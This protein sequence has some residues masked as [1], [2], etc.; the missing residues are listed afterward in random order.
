MT[1]ND[2]RTSLSLIERLQNQEEQAWAHFD[3][4]YGPIIYRFAMAQGASHDVAEEVRS[5]SYVAV[6][7]QIKQLQYD[8]QRGRFR[9]WLLTIAS[10]RL[11]D[12]VRQR[13]GLQADSKILESLEGRDATPQQ[14]W[15]RQWQQ[16]LLLEAFQ[17]VEGRMGDESREIFRRLVRESQPVAE[18]ARDLDVS[19]NKIYKTKQRSVDML[20]EE[21]R[22]LEHDPLT[23]G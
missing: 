15:E 17:R 9:N 8:Q 3:A 7:K 16:Q 6:V 4:F 2:S 19:E 23:A 20:R 12:L 14:E 21:L 1:P 13:P 18:I 22:F 11:A 5:A 10:R